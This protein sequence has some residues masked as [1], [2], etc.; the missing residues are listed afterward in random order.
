MRMK[1]V[2]LDR[3]FDSV[4]VLREL[5]TAELPCIMPAVKRGQKPPTAGGPTGTS[6]LAAMTQGPWTS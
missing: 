1:L 5:L 2:L 4:R 6:A 3:G